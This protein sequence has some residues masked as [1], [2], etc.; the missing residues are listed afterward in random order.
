MIRKAL[1]ILLLAGLLAIPNMVGCSSGTEFP[2]GITGIVFE[3]ANANGVQDEDEGGVKGVLVSDGVYCR[4]TNKAGEYNLPA[5]E[6]LVFITTPADY[7]PTGQWYATISSG[8]LDFGLRHTPEKDSS[9]FTF[10]QMTDMHVDQEHETAFSELI[11]ELNEMG[12][13]FVV[14]TG[15]LINE[16]NAATVAEAEQ[17]FDVYENATSTLS[18]PLY[19]AVGNHDVVGIYSDDVPATDPAYGEGIFVRRFGPTYYSYDWGDYHCIVLDPND[20]V[21]G[22][23]IYQISDTQL[24]WLKDDLKR[25]K[26]A[27]LLIFFHEPTAS[28]RNRSEVL[29]ALKGH[30]AKLFCGHLHQD[31]MTSATDV[32]EQI[33]GAVCG[34]WWHGANPDGKPAGYRI[35]T[36]KGEEVDSLYKGTGEERTIDPGLTPIVNGQVDLAIKIYSKNGPVDSGVTYQVD[37]GQPV[38]MNLEPYVMPFPFL[39]SWGVATASWDTTSL[40]EGYHRITF[41]ATDSAGSFEKQVEVKV[42]DTE[43]VSVSDL[44]SHWGVYQGAYVPLEGSASLSIIGPSATYRIPEGMGFVMVSDGTDMAVAIAGE[45][46]SPPLSEIKLKLRNNDQVVV[47]VVPLRLSMGFLA[48]TREYEE[49]YSSISGYVSMLPDSAM[50]GPKGNPVAVWGAR[51]LSGDDLTILPD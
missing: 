51:W 45:C 34:E 5:E 8:Q 18:M 29:A 6:S 38:A 3:D 12:P 17:C 1:A 50:E 16:G 7:T 24:Q 47:K 10:V 26:G 32:Y 48:S 20:L 19:N 40:A 46:F 13:A 2:D 41:N 9:D 36:V 35:I 4:S 23:Q 49:Y 28:W 11:T 31:T 22:Q 43:T 25:R 27:P 37:D 33:T 44:T 14:S 15:D 39:K 21:D 30:S 42:S